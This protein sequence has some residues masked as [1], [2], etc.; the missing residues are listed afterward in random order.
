MV[1]RWQPVLQPPVLYAHFNATTTSD[2]PRLILVSLHVAGAERTVFLN[3]D[4]SNSSTLPPRVLRGWN[5]WGYLKKSTPHQSKAH[6]SI[7]Q[8]VCS[9]GINQQVCFSGD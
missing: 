9:S 2:D 7:N 6:P 4:Y 1:H 8:H 5:F 3:E